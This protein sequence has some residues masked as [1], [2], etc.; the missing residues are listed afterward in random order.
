ML[1]VRRALMKSS[2]AAPAMPYIAD[3][4]DLYSAG[5]TFRRGEVIMV[6][7][8][9]GSQKSGFAIWLAVQWNLPTLYFAADMTL[10][11]ISVRAGAA[12]LGKGEDEIVAAMKGA[13]SQQ[14][15]DMLDSIPFTIATGTITW[16]QVNAQIMA[17]V[18]VHDAMPEL[19]VIDNL[20]DVEGAVADYTAQMEVM[21]DLVNLA[22]ETGS[23]V[24]VLH[25]ATD[26]S[27]RAR[28]DT[29]APPARAD[30][31][32]GMSEKPQTILGVTIDNATDQFRV[33]VLKQRMGKS[34]PS[35]RTF[36]VLKCIP[37]YTQ[38]KRWVSGGVELYSGDIK[39]PH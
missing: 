33:A 11:E 38:F 20:M 29:N 27:D 3:L 13:G 39:I 30:I 32:N 1:N 10:Y 35:G 14:E 6:A 31:K 2:E 15:M 28:E 16:D 25:H 19:I 37:Q 7:G 17:Y 8:R 21:E 18:E 22:R 9:S 4:E 23:T 34:D 24:L 36:S 5:L 26:K 12:K